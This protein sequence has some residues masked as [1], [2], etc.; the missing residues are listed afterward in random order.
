MPVGLAYVQREEYFYDCMKRDC[1]EGHRIG[2]VRGASEGDGMLESSSVEL[3][4]K[5]TKKSCF[6]GR[7]DSDS[8][9][10]TEKRRKGRATEVVGDTFS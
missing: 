7:R 2:L 10:G 6:I 4:E 8:I 1:W 9:I 5:R 3:E